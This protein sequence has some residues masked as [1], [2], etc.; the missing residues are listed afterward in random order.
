LKYF[1]EKAPEYAIAA[2]GSLLGI[3][4]GRKDGFPVGKV[5]FMQVN[6]LTF[7]EYLEQAN[8]TLN[9]YLNQIGGTE[10][11]PD[12]FFNPILEIFNQYFICG[13]MPEAASQLIV[14]A[15]IDKTNEVLDDILRAYTLDFVKHAAPKDIAKINHVWQSIPA[16]LAKENRKF[17][18]Q[19]VKPGARAREYEDALLWLFQAGLVHRVYSCSK[20]SL[21]LS[22]YDDLSAFKLYLNDVG[23]LRQLSKIDVSTISQKSQ[24][25]TEFKGAF[26]ENYVLQSLFSQF[27]VMPRYWTSIGKAEVDF[28]IQYRNM[29]IPC[30]VKADENVQSKSLAVYNQQFNP[31]IRIRYSLKNLQFRDGLLNIPLFMAD[32]TQRL[33]DFIFRFES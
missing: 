22:A 17:L 27:E 12:I 23:L 31:L 18:Y 29:I 11:I 26:A 24:L 14:S 19:V 10:P 8:V 1:Y 15:S 4:L 13:G 6:P 33:I 3:L 9:N 30:E 21:P 32:Q 20:P 16:Q 2:A 28:V 7:S 25:F 5:N